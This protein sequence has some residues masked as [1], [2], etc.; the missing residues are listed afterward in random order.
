MAVDASAEMRP[1]ETRRRRE[2]SSRRLHAPGVAASETLA[3]TLSCLLLI[4]ALLLGGGTRNYLFTD[5][6]VQLLASVLLVYAVARLRW[7]TVD[8]PHRQ[9]LTLLALVLA[10]PLLQLLPLPTALMQ[11]FPG[12]GE[13]WSEYAGLGLDVPM[14][15]PWSLDPNATLAALRSLLPAAALVLLASQL[16]LLWRRRLVLIV[17]AIA[18]LNVPFGIAQVAQGVHS[19][20]RPYTPTNVHDAVGLFANRNHYAA[21]LVCGLVFVFGGLLLNARSGMAQSTRA[22]H[23][24]GWMLLGGMLLLGDMLSRS[25]AGVGLAGLVAMTMLVLAYRRRQEQ[26]QIFRWFLVFIVIG[27]LLAFQFGFMA[28]ADRLTQAG[29]QR[30]DVT[31]GVL[32]ASAKFAWLGSGIGSFPAVYAAYEPIELVGARILNHAHNDW[33]E[34]WVDLGILLIPMA[35]LLAR[36]LL[37]RIRELR[38]GDNLARPEHALRLVGIGVIVVLCVHSLVDYPLRTTAVSCV[39]ALAAVLACTPVT[40][41]KTPLDSGRA[42]DS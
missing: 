2:H 42:A 31:A 34:L 10:L 28:I 25:R 1:W 16:G 23:M 38:A 13:L 14:F 20:L 17:V 7:Q 33:A 32:A 6:V 41:R 3:G 11:W 37:L 18:L 30:W 26:P 27:G 35:L 24:I 29:D 12:R 8:Q 22:L 9:L 5:L 36:F 40:L 21:L 19:E 4:F 15:A 39:F